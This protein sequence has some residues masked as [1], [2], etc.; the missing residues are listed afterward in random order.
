MVAWISIFTLAGVIIWLSIGYLR[1]RL[2][3]Q[4]YYST[5]TEYYT[6][7]QGVSFLGGVIV[8]IAVTATMPALL[9]ALIIGSTAA[10]K[11][12]A[13]QY[14]IH[15]LEHEQ[16]VNGSFFIGCGR[17]K[18]V[19]VLYFYYEEENGELVYTEVSQDGCRVF[20]ENT[21]KAVFIVKQPYFKNPEIARWTFGAPNRETL[22]EIRVPKGTI[23]PVVDFMDTK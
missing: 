14:N 11:Y 4:G 19:A 23:K 12:E 8:L 15:A 1:W 3:S 10:V 18:G 22:Y 7:G 9:L 16:R 6:Q 2:G 13:A 20:E 21:Q 5:L 17:V